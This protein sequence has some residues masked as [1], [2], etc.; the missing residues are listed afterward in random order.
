M[1][2]EKVVYQRTQ[3]SLKYEGQQI[4]LMANNVEYTFSYVA[5]SDIFNSSLSSVNEIIQSFEVN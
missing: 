1:K 2:A 4:Y 3:A 5:P